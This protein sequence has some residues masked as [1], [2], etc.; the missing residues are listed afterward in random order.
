MNFARR[1][2]PALV[3][4]T[5]I[6]PGSIAEAQ[7]NPRHS[8]LTYAG[9]LFALADADEVRHQL[10]P[11]ASAATVSRKDG[12][13][14][15]KFDTGYSRIVATS[16]F[17]KP[18]RFSNLPSNDSE[19]SFS[20]EAVSA[21]VA[22]LHYRTKDDSRRYLSSDDFAAF[23]SATDVNGVEDIVSFFRLS[24]QP[25]VIGCSPSLDYHLRANAEN[26]F[27][28]WSI[29]ADACVDN[30]NGVELQVSLRK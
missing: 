25:N 19:L 23:S 1:F 29:V 12:A 24:R 9:V 11:Q 26:R 7:S 6:N 27:R 15:V 20:R 28:V 13:Y 14:L 2:L 3:L 10:E 22:T 30:R 4:A 8:T 16:S 17:P 5:A 21:I 18:G